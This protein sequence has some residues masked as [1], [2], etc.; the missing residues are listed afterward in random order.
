MI[1]N[2]CLSFGSVHSFSQSVSLSFVYFLLPFHLAK[3]NENGNKCVINTLMKV[4]LFCCF[5]KFFVIKKKSCDKTNLLRFGGEKIFRNGLGHSALP[6]TAES[7][8]TP[9]GPWTI[10]G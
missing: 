4:F 3:K 1:A 6:W 8:G 9:L 2:I 10:R 7:H 5:P